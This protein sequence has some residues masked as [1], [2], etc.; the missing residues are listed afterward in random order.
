MINWKDEPHEFSDEITWQDA[1][2]IARPWIK[3]PRNPE[4]QR[5]YHPDKWAAG[6]CDLVLRWDGKT[7]IVDIKMGDGT[8]KFASSLQVN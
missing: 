7:R 1:W 2:E 8:G 4:P 6:E 3:D 5:M